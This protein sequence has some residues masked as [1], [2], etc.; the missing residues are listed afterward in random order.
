MIPGDLNNATLPTRVAIVEQD[1]RRESEPEP[2]RKHNLDQVGFGIC[3]STL[4]SGVLQPSCELGGL[5]G[6]RCGSRWVCRGLQNPHVAQ[7]GRYTVIVGG[8]IHTA[9]EVQK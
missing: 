5:P 1:P 8:R 6:G 7:L 2:H 9:Q 3:E 4:R